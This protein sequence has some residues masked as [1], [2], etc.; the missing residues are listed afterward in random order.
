M[1]PVPV[2]ALDPV[3]KCFPYDKEFLIANCL[4]YMLFCKGILRELAGMP[5]LFMVKLFAATHIGTPFTFCFH[6]EVSFSGKLPIYEKKR[7]N[8]KGFTRCG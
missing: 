5:F 8:G 6:D 7:D 1:E 3:F 2:P 4:F